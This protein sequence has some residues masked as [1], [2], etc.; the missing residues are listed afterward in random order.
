MD[1]HTISRIMF[2]TDKV[3]ADQPFILRD[4]QVVFART[5]RFFPNQLAEIQIGS[6][7]LIAKLEVP[8]E[9]GKGYWFQ[10]AFQ[11]GELLLKL[12]SKE[13]PRTPGPISLDHSPFPEQKGLQELTNFL[14]KEPVPLTKE[15]IFTA[16]RWLKTVNDQS[17]AMDVIR[18][19]SRQNLPF[20]DSVFQS[21]FAAVNKTSFTNLMS[22]LYESL[23]QEPK[24]APLVQ[25]ILQHLEELLHH[26]SHQEKAHTGTGKDVF[27]HLMRAIKHTGIFYE[28][29]MEQLKPELALKSLLVKYVGINEAGNTSRNYAEQIILK[30]N[31]QQLFSANNT[32]VQQI[33]FTIPLTVFQQYTEL[34]MQWTAKRKPDGKIDADYCRILFYLD[35]QHLKE[36]VVDM[37]IQNRVVTVTLFNE[38]E[39]IKPLAQTLMPFLKEELKNLD[40]TLSTVHIRKPANKSPVVNRLSGLE[41]NPYTGV[42]IRI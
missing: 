21:L 42:D 17:L 28:A 3:P 15:Q 14:M 20:I 4:G 24:N 32:S 2:N 30:M 25:Q 11:Q 9:S 33:V 12:L 7:R 10:A 34:T 6:N 31:G 13:A 8:L 1:I 16:G 26:G 38:S 27:Q 19:M 29:N 37:Q 41:S 35:L 18:F 40:Y 36:T 22:S 23:Q 39:A 5:L